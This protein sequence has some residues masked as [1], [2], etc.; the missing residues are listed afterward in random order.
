MIKLPFAL[1]LMIITLGFFSC[2]TYYIP[3]DSFK[4]Q[5]EG[6]NPS[7]EVIVRGPGGGTEKYMT[8]PISTISCVDKNGQV[9]ELK[10]SPSLEIRFSYGDK[11]H[12]IFYF[13]LMRINDTS[14]SGGRSRF[15]PSLKKTIPLNAIKKIEIQDGHKKYRYVN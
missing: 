10:N 5:F 2:K 11:R 13:D 3:L 8:Y 7:R 9:V 6:L 4:K 12:T 14:L 15:M 1:S